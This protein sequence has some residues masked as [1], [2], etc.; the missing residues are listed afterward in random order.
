MKNR[1]LIATV[2]GGALLAGVLAGPA[3]ADTGSTTVTFTLNT[4]GLEIDTPVANAALATAASTVNFTGAL[5]E[6]TVTDNRNSTVGW[7]A[8]AF[9]TDFLHEDYDSEDPD[10]AQVIEA[11][12]VDIAIDGNPVIDLL[13]SLQE[14]LNP[15]APLFTAT[16]GTAGDNGTTVGGVRVGGT[17][18]EVTNASLL[19]ALD[20]LVG[21]LLGFLGNDVRHEVAYDPTVTVNVPADKVNGLYTGTITQTVL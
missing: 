15:A 5:G 21:G 20:G 1:K 6:T 8:S 2:A 11:E 13:G 10:Q 9:S 14:V 12:Y 7:V 18:G 19:G 16:A 17:I 3:M 4:G